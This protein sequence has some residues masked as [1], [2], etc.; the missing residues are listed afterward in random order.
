MT[1]ERQLVAKMLNPS[2]KGASREQVGTVD[3]DNRKFVG[4][5]FG[6]WNSQHA[7]QLANTE[8]ASN[9]DRRADSNV[10]RGD[11]SML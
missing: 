6:A 1:R 4:G 5:M 11:E 9:C 8:R 3:A 10:N 2:R 7:R